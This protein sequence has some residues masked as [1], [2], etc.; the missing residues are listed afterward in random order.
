MVKL[1]PYASSWRRLLYGSPLHT[2]PGKVVCALDVSLAVAFAVP[3]WVGWLTPLSNGL[4]LLVAVA[5]ALLGSWPAL[6][7][8]RYLDRREPEPWLYWLVALLFSALVAPAAAAF[9][10]DHSPFSTLTVGFNEEFWKVYVLLML[11]AFVPTV[12]SGVRDG[13]VYGALG[14]VGFNVIEIA[15]YVLRVS[16][17]KDGL[18]A[19]VSAQLSRLGWWGVGNHIVWSALVGAGIGY[20]VQ[21][22]RSKWTFL[23]PIGA[24]LLAV[25][26]HTLQDNVL[27]IVLIIGFTIGI[28]GLAGVDAGSGPGAHASKEA[29]DMAS[30]FNPTA[31]A[32]EVVAINIVNIPILIYAL[33]R[34][35]DWERGVILKQL[36]GESAE[37][38]TAE[39]LA[40]IK[41][42]K[43]FRTRRIP[44]YPKSV[45]RAIRNT[46]N[47]LAFHKQYL[48]ARGLSSEAEFLAQYY[49][50]ELARL[51]DLP[52]LT[53][54]TIPFK[55]EA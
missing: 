38:V 1:N 21:A 26:T 32:L 33:W 18:L 25:L 23:V 27:G 40:G 29:I 31:M 53:L 35:G 3:T 13:V 9:F 41:S 28:L 14:G 34:S 7:L 2:T 22:P 36:A 43:R 10:N 42:A 24:Y 54:T 51:R 48:A 50:D 5:F 16:N 39:E 4:V 55:E 47:S 12:V 37:V 6:L 30:R 49:R 11:V 46:Q 15:A 20:A 52:G 45:G 19:G 44:G 8:L 17:P